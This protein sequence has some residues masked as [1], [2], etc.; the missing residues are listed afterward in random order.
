ML[1][2]VRSLP[3]LANL[4]YVGLGVETVKRAAPESRRLAMDSYTRFL[5][6]ALGFGGPM[7]GLVRDRVGT[8]SVFL[9]GALCSIAALV[10]SALWRFSGDRIA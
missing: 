4:V 10:I 9:V 3:G 1:S 5:E 8:R 2:L 7:L 6:L